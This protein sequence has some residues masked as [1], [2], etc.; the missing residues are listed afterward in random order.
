MFREYAHFNESAI[1]SVERFQ[2]DIIKV[3]FLKYTGDQA[4]HNSAAQI[5]E[6]RAWMLEFL[7]PQIRIIQR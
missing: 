1:R 4:L 6:P 5:R 7:L 2:H 3:L